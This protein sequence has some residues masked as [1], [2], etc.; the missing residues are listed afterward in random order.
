MISTNGHGAPAATLLTLDELRAVTTKLVELPALSAAAGSPRSV[1][2]RRI[3]REHYYAMLPDMPPGA[4]AWPQD[5]AARSVCL[6]DWLRGLPPAGRLAWHQEGADV[7]AHV[8]AA[9]A[10]EPK[11]TAD[12]ASGLADDCQV[13]ALAILAFSDLLVV[14]EAPSSAAPESVSAE[15][16]AE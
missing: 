7:W 10:V 13:L 5:A 4:E 8:C 3:R 1:R 14:P 16:L 11:L 15:S 12:D 2:I 9:G 6:A